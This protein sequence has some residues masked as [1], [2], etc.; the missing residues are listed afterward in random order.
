MLIDKNHYF[1]FTPDVIL[2]IFNDEALVVNLETEMI[3]AMNGTGARVAE[4]IARR[5]SVGGILAILRKEYQV[6]S[7]ELES[8]VS[9]LFKALLHRQL[10]VNVGNH[11]TPK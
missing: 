6:D 2:K 10:I 8:G 1:A 7:P 9:E 3:F 5:I 11:D 4:L